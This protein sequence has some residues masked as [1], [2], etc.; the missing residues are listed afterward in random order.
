MLRL[1]LLLLAALLLITG[2]F[3][4]YHSA[5]IGSWFGE[6]P[7]NQAARTDQQTDIASLLRWF[8]YSDLFLGII[9]L[10]LFFVASTSATIIFIVIVLVVSTAFSLS[11]AR[12][13]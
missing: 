2:L 10:I 3:L 12:K 5:K 13:F 6:P 1:L 4:K 7:N 9:G 11:L 8:G